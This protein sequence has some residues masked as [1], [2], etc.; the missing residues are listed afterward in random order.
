MVGDL[1]GGQALRG[2]GRARRLVVE[3]AA[4]G[5]AAP[6]CEPGG[7]EPDGAEHAAQAQHAPRPVQRPEE[8]ALVAS[9]RYAQAGQVGLED[10]K[11]GNGNGEHRAQALH[12]FLQA[13]DAHKKLR[14]RRVQVG[15]RYHLAAAA[16]QPSGRR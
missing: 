2:R 7:R 10:P 14:R 15:Q 1:L 9:V 8:P 5:G 12:A 6:R 11:E 13:G 16:R 4:T 3:F